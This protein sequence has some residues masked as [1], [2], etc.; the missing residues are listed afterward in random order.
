MTTNLPRKTYFIIIKLCFAFICLFSQSTLAFDLMLVG[1]GMKT[2]SS[3]ATSLCKDDTQFSSEAKRENRYLVHSKQLERALTHPALS[4]LT[5]FQRNAIARLNSQF[6]QS[7]QP[8]SLAQLSAALDKAEQQFLAKLSDA[9][10]YALLDLLQSPATSE[11]TIL[12]HKEIVA[13]DATKNPNGPM[14]YQRF[15]QETSS[16]LASTESGQ[17]PKIII[18]TASSRDPFESVE[19][20]QQAFEQAGADAVWLPLDSALQ[21]ALSTKQCQKLNQYRF[22]LQGNLDGDRRYP[23]LAKLQLDYCQAPEKILTELESANGLFLNGGDQSLTLKAW[24]TPAGNESEALSRVKQRLSDQTLVVGGT[25]AGTAVMSRFAMIT[26]GSSKGA[27]DFGIFDAEPT[28]ERCEALNCNSKIPATAVTYRKQGGLGLFPFGITDTH[29]SE[30]HRQLRLIMLAAETSAPLAFGIDENT[31]MLVDVHTQKLE[32]VGEHGV[33]IFQNAEVSNATN[34]VSRYRTNSHYLTSGDLAE[35][36]KEDHQLNI[37]SQVDTEKSL[38]TN[39]DKI[40]RRAENKSSSSMFDL[41]AKIIDYCLNQQQSP[42][43]Y[44][45]QSDKARITIK[46]KANTDNACQKII[47]NQNQLSHDNINIELS[48]SH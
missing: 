40:S 11:S 2:C 26:G 31:A 38:A 32:F 21:M 43:V 16:R 30:R 5:A 27:L 28:S 41:Q 20:Y 17:R 12:R 34:S 36:N 23:K 10:Y 42:G 44:Q 14:L 45:W 1:G 4:E 35:I 47:K 46:L 29:F 22:E 13:L 8:V 48:V 3:M 39:A 9:H 15:V 37:K 6:S 33:W 19:F 24:L 18:V 7:P 25:S